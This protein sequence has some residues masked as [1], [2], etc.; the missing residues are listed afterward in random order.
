MRRKRGFSKFRK[1]HQHSTLILLI[2]AIFV[3]IVLALSQVTYTGQAS[4]FE[5]P[6]FEK[7]KSETIQEKKQSPIIEENYEEDQLIVQFRD[8]KN[9]QEKQKQLDK[10]KKNIKNYKRSF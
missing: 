7:F 4:L 1:K 3:L 6:L 10:H 8:T 5:G 2:I 9:K